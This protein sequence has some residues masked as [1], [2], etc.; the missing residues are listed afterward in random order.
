MTIA[1]LVQRTVHL[2][3]ISS[4]A[5]EL[6]ACRSAVLALKRAIT[7]THFEDEHLGSISES[8]TQIQEIASKVLSAKQTY[9]RFKNCQF[10]I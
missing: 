3:D 6:A 7:G 9:L 5:A 10:K 8:D 4:N 1:D 2:S